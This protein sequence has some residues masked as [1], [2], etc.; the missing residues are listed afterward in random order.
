MVCSFS[1][2]ISVSTSL[3]R[4]WRPAKCFC[5]GL[6]SLLC[7]DALAC[8]LLEACLLP[9]PDPAGEFGS[10]GAASNMSDA[11][12]RLWDA[13]VEGTERSA[14]GGRVLS[15]NLAWSLSMIFSMAKGTQFAQ[16]SISCC[17]STTLILV[18]TFSARG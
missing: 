2:S 11:G 1:T 8:C 6:G 7:G 16:S 12:V 3:C 14:E 15:W 17:E 18:M 13:A 4:S 9:A 5:L 10:S